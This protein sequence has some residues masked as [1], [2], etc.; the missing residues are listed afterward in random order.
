MVVERLLRL[1]HSPD[2]I[3]FSGDVL[4]VGALLTCQRLGVAVPD[5]VAIASFDD[6]EIAEQLSPSL[7]ALRLPRYE[8]GQKAAELVIKRLSG[9]S[10]EPRSIDLGIELLHRKST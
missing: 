5:G 1:R 10:A 3:F 6:H 9:V 7:T 8:I 4:A 2:A